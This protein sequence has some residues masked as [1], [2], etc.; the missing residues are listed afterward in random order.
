MDIPIPA[1]DDAIRSIKLILGKLADAVY[2]GRHG[3]LDT[4]SDYEE[5]EETLAGDE[6]DFEDADWI[7]GFLIN[8]THELTPVDIKTKA[9]MPSYMMVVLAL[10]NDG[11]SLGM[12]DQ[13][14]E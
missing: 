8:I 6:A 7:V 1:N 9:L 14:I 11:C 4:D 13:N 5:F 10:E 2:E 3:Q 12:T